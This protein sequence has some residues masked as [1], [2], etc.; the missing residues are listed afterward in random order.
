MAYNYE[1]PYTDP[2]RY[3]SDWILSKM[4]DIEARLDGIVE[5]TV[6]QTKIYVDEQLEYYQA[7]VNDILAQFHALEKSV[8][9]SID[10]IDDKLLTSIEA[11]DKKVEEAR[12]EA[13]TLFIE[14][15]ARTDYL[16]RQNNEYIFR[17][18]EDN[19]LSNITVINY[20]TGERISVQDMFDYLAQFHLENSINYNQLADKNITVSELIAKRITYTELVK[21]GSILI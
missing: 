8:D 11:M 15:N 6:R 5:E 14:A 7:Q 10:A 9:K 13:K 17:E 18:I 21:N 2:N 20:F 1:Y 4:K 16:I 12:K 3:N 19:I